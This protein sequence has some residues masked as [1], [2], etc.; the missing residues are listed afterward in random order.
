MLYGHL[1]LCR[2]IIKNQNKWR[3]D[4]SPSKGI[5]YQV[6]RPELDYSV[7]NHM[8]GESQLLLDVLWHSMACVH[9]ST[10]TLNKYIK[11]KWNINK[12]LAI[13]GYL[14]CRRP[15]ISNKNNHT[16]VSPLDYLKNWSYILLS[17]SMD[18]ISVISASSHFSKVNSFWC[19]LP[20]SL[21]SFM[22]LLSF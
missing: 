17:L 19:F 5:Y 16:L 8:V 22:L 6:W 10:H 18:K 3:W 15:W 4:Y 13:W 21:T 20:W 2:L 11:L 1:L 14:A 7:P 12:G 9:L